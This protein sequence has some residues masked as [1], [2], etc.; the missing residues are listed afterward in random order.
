MRRNAPC[1]IVPGL[2][3]LVACS[4]GTA[5]LEEEPVSPPVEIVEHTV[6]YTIDCS[7]YSDHCRG[8]TWSQL[9]FLREYDRGSEFNRVY[10]TAQR[11]TSCY[12]GQWLVLWLRPQGNDGVGRVSATISVDGTVVKT[13]SRSSRGLRGLLVWAICE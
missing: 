8:H 1:G 11:T 10:G 13:R 3:A 7:H 5:A 12:A 4:S 6:T 9:L 2:L